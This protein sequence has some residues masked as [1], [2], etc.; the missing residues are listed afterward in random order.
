MWPLSVRCRCYLSGLNFYQLWWNFHKFHLFQEQIQSE[1]RICI[2]WVP[3][4]YSSCSLLSALWCFPFIVPLLIKC[5][6]ITKTNQKC[7]LEINQQSPVTDHWTRNNGVTPG[8]LKKTNQTNK[9]NHLWK[10]RWKLQTF[11]LLQKRQVNSLI[12]TSLE[13][14]I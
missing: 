4:L 2:K 11:I 13:L 10:A 6:I 8:L 3:L 14:Y 9:I 5:C 12:S 1:C 7:L